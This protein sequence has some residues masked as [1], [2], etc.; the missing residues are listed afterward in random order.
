MAIKPKAASKSKTPSKKAAK[1]RGLGSG[2]SSLLGDAAVATTTAGAQPANTGSPATAKAASRSRAP[3]PAAAS[4]A[5]GLSELP[6]EWINSGPW[7]PRRRFDDAGLREL[8]ESVRGKG[9]VQPVL[10]RPKA[11][12][13]DR[14]ELI[15]GERR[16]RAAQMAK[17]HKIPAIIR[18]LSD[19]EAH[20]V[21]IIENVQRANLSA[22]EEAE[23][24]RQ[25]IE[26]F[27]HTQEEIAKT[28]GKSRSHIANLLRLL[29]LPKKV[30]DMV[31]EGALSMGQARPLVGNRRCVELAR[32][33]ADKGLSARQAEALAV[34]PPVDTEAQKL[35]RQKPA[36]ITEIEQKAGRAL[37][38]RI[39]IDWDEKKGRGRMNLRFTSL[40][41]FEDVMRRLGVG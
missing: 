31:I 5:T 3:G 14:Y 29:S 19:A 20:E 26:T 33:I 2:L 12:K 28:V 23:G 34:K 11:G 17:L 6:V 32:Q 22:I 39:D 13:R 9:I 25:L 8:A 36:D 37:G 24:Y 41:Q 7:Q 1:K 15:A 10:V 30:K 38:L 4:P 35:R 40:D 16:W 27:G 21:A 18:K